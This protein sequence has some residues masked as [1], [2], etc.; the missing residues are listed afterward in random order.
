MYGAD[1][2]PRSGWRD[3]HLM[4]NARD[5]IGV[6]GLTLTTAG[7]AWVYPPAGCI[8]PGLFLLAAAVFWRM[9]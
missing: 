4:V 3:V 2:R 5:I 6:V 7:A 9:R 1:A 8:V